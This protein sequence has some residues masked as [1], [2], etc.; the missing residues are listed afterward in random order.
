MTSVVRLYVVAAA[1]L[2]LFL[3]WAFAAA[4][5]WGDPTVD[6]RVQA[7][8]VREQ[9]VRRESIEVKRL[10]DRRWTLYRAR[11]TERQLA[12]RAMSQRAAAARAAAAAAPVVRMVPMPP[13]TTTRS[14]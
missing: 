14:S 13:V 2:V 1:I 11:L 6:P 7:L 3:A 4:R 9:R 12:I 5:P 8:A 10:V